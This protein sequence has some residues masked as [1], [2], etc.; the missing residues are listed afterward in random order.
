MVVKNWGQCIVFCSGHQLII[1]NAEKTETITLPEAQ[2][3]E[4]RNGKEH[5]NISN[6]CISKDS[7]LIA[8]STENK[9]IVVFNKQL[10][11]VKNFNV[12]R[13]SSQ[14]CFTPDNSLIVA[15]KT[16]DVYLYNLSSEIIS[17]LLLLGHMS[18]VLDVLVTDCGK[19]I[20][21]CDRDEKIR[22]SRFP[23]SYNIQSFCLGH[24]EFVIAL[25]TIG[26]KLISASGDGT[27]K[28]WDY[29]NG[30][31]LGMINVNESIDKQ[32][33]HKF[34]E[35]MNS[36]DIEVSALPITDMQLHSVDTHFF[37]GV[38]LFQ[39]EKLLL[40]SMNSESFKVEFC[41]HIF[42]NSSYC[43]DLSGELLILTPEKL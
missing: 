12:G 17:P 30:N 21:T 26:N 25:K 29:I 35:E 38:S 2:S 6:L 33:I 14:I 37:I 9:Q 10:I 41:K 39:Q 11:V 27:I 43:F 15:D 5:G 19:Y 34:C 7:S 24:K 36:E 40:Y 23:N 8:V 32:D 4:N 18:V 31:E 13:V 20:I 16:G 3:C 22:V 1:H 28:C 42:V